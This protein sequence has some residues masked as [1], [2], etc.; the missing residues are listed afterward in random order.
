MGYTLLSEEYY[1]GENMAKKYHVTLTDRERAEL[2]DIIRRRSEKSLPVIRSY[3]LLAADMNGDKCWTDACISDTYGVRIITVE[4]TR[5]RFVEEGFDIAVRGKKRDV[6]RE[7][8]LDGNTEAH[9]IALR[10]SEPPSGYA[11]WTLRLLSDKMV[12]LE[13]TEHISHESV[14][15]ILKKRNETLAGKVVDNSGSRC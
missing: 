9:L 1:K 12:E 5:K 7:K 10:C 4:R 14:R 15:Q 11:R 6:F 2:A 3:I 8:I 13:Y